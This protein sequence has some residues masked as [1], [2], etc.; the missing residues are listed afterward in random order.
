M[1]VFYTFGKLL[2][3]VTHLRKPIEQIF[4]DKKI[5]NHATQL[6]KNAQL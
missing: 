6:Q 4:V 1:V 2:V 5:K 3:L